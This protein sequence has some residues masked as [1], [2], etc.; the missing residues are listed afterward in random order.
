M[1]FWIANCVFLDRKRRF[2]RLGT[3]FCLQN[4]IQERRLPGLLTDIRDY[5]IVHHLRYFFIQNSAKMKINVGYLAEK[6]AQNNV[7]VYYYPTYYIKS[8]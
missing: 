7:N 3:Q 1:T 2:C 4:C 6:L 8:Y 5:G